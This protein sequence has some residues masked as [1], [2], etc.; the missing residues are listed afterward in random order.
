MNV[1]SRKVERIAWIDQRFEAGKQSLQELQIGNISDAGRP[2]DHEASLYLSHSLNHAK[3]VV[4]R[5]KALFDQEVTQALEEKDSHPSSSPVARGSRIL[6]IASVR[7][8]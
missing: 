7:A 1:A 3:R 8:V 6:R 4:P 5:Q 2:V